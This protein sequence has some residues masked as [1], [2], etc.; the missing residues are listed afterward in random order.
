MKKN[1]NNR[2]HIEGLLYQHSLELKVSGENSKNPGTEFIS[3]TIEIAHCPCS[4]Y[5]FNSNYFYW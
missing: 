4:F 5:L 3:G 2:S 1:M